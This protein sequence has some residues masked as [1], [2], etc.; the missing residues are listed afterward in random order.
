[1]FNQRGNMGN[2]GYSFKSYVDAFCILAGFKGEPTMNNKSEDIRQTLIEGASPHK[3]AERVVKH[4][5]ETYGVRWPPAAIVQIS[6]LLKINI[7]DASALISEFCTQKIR[8]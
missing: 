4:A 5:R 7:R 2:T 6:I 3:I 1:M 8:S